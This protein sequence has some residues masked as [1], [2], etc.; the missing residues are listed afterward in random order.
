MTSARY[1]A[2]T[3]ACTALLSLACSAAVFTVDNTS[4]VPD[5]NP[6][7]AVCATAAMQCTLRAAIQEANA[8]GGANTVNVP[9]GTYSVATPLFSTNATN[10]L[11]INGTGAPLTTIIDGGLV[12]GIF[13]LQQGTTNLDNVVVRNGSI[14]IT[15]PGSFGV[16]TGAGLFVS[17]PATANIT[18]SL[19]TGNQTTNGSGGGLCVLGTVTLTRT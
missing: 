3:I 11:T 12:T 17:T 14:T 10:A 1:V 8:L 13:S 5:A 18:N 15:N 16:C 9:A 6:G 4:D 2:A 19:I 7:D